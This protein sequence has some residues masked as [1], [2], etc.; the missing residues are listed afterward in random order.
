MYAYT[1]SCH[2]I[3]KEI[4]NKKPKTLTYISHTVV[5][6]FITWRVSELRHGN[7]SGGELNGYHPE[8]Y[9]WLE[10]SGQMATEDTC[11]RK[12]NIH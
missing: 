4:K 12:D 3:K 11:E 7:T 10:F 2:T 9:K 1:T 8:F 5:E 6:P